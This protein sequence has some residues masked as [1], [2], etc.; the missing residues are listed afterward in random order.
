MRRSHRGRS[1]PD[2]GAE[3]RFCLL[4]VA[5]VS[6]RRQITLPS[7]RGVALLGWHPAKRE[8]MGENTKAWESPQGGWRC[9]PCQN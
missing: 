1:G 3:C 5:G 6:H 2:Q 4:A 9:Q 8:P 7:A